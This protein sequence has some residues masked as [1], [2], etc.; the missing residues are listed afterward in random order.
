[1]GFKQY[2]K[3]DSLK[4]ME[5]KAKVF[6]DEIKK[7]GWKKAGIGFWIHSK[8][9]NVLIDNNS[10]I[11]SA[12]YY[13]DVKKDKYEVDWTPTENYK[14]LTDWLKS[15]EY[16]NLQ[17]QTAVKK[18]FEKLAKSNGWKHEY[19]HQGDSYFHKDVPDYAIEDSSIIGYISV[20]P[21][22][23]DKR[24]DYRSTNFTKHRTVKDAA[25]KLLSMKG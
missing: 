22:E 15:S 6:E 12:R 3:E 20:G 9:P 14:D 10:L 13:H 16:K 8:Y 4:Q 17:Y 23:R 24:I 21:I 2:L 5:A 19:I 11:A 7:N 18:D 25:K 1:M